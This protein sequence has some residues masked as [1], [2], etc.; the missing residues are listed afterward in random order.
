M[1]SKPEIHANGKANLL[2][3]ASDSVTEAHPASRI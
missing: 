2:F 3:R 1:T